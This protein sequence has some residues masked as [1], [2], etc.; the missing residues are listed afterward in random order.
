MKIQRHSRALQLVTALMAAGWV[1]LSGAKPLLYGQALEDQ[2]AQHQQLAQQAEAKEDFPTAVREYEWIVRRLPENA[3][4]ESNLAV[5]LYFNNQQEQAAAACRR[6]IARKPELYAP[7]LFLGLALAKLSQPDKAASELEKALAI[8]PSDPLAHTWL[9]YEYMDQARYDDA[10]KH[11]ET[12]ASAKPQDIDIWFSLGQSYLESGK[13]AT[14]QLVIA[15]PDGGRTW[16]LAAEQ[17]ELQENR[18][19]ALHLYLEANKRRPDIEAVR[20]EILALGGKVPEAAARSQ[21]ATA[22]EDELYQRTYLFEKK[23]QD[24]FAHVSKIDPDSYRAHEIAADGD[25]AAGRYDDA[26]REY[27]LVVQ[28]KSNIPGVHASLCDSL[29]RVD[30]LNDALKE[31]EAEIAVSPRSTGAYVGVARIYLLTDDYDHAADVLQKAKML[32]EPPVAAYKFWGQL[33]F[34][35]KR[36]PEAV[37]AFQQYLAAEPRDSSAYILLARCYKFTGDTKRMNEAIATYKK[38]SAEA[39][40]N[41]E[42]QQTLDETG[43]DVREDNSKGMS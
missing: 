12:A 37:H 3:E 26:I 35:Q 29:V 39:R 31:C 20:S 21:E 4:A 32:G 42:A 19:R 36:Y 17:A 34:H 13:A 7:H 27:T 1:F 16:Q 18:G 38:I 9:G 28:R 22:N 5:A 10:I 23:A 2:L 6:A 8:N 41:S 43:N 40:G 14:K 25:L 24:A 33:Y 30:K 15:Y 11:L